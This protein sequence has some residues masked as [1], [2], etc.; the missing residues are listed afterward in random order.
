MK[1]HLGKVVKEI[2]DS[3][4]GR[5]TNL[6]AEVQ[7]QWT[8]FEKWEDRIVELDSKEGTVMAE[9]LIRLSVQN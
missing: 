3:L 2:F 1:E 8:A 7:T 4:E 6:E 5:L 9:R